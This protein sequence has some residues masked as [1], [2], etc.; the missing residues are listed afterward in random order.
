MFHFARPVWLLAVF[1]NQYHSKAWLSGHH[2]VISFAR[3]GERHDFDH[4][5]DIFEQRKLHRFLFVLH[6]TGGRPGDGMHAKNEGAG[7]HFQW[8]L[9]EP[10]H[11]QFSSYGQSFH[12]T[13]HCL[14][15]GSSSEDGIGSAKRSQLCSRIFRPAVDVLVRAE[16][17][18]ELLRLRTETDGD[19]PESHP[20]RVLNP[21]VT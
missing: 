16:L 3:L 15:T 12:E 8:I 7:S 10:N 19:S 2:P 18:C 4:R 6:A 1:G 5:L 20:S 14:T 13:G 11:Q 9:G 21:E 17:L